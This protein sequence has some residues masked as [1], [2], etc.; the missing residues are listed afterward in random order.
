M[1]DSIL[2]LTL[3]AN[4]IFLCLWLL[5]SSLCQPKAWALDPTV[6]AL[7]NYEI[8]FNSPRERESAS[9]SSALRT[10]APIPIEDY[11]IPLD[12]L[13]ADIAD[14]IPPELMHSLV[15]EK[16]GIKYVRWLINPEDQSFFH[17]VESFLKI[18]GISTERHTYFTAYRT[19]SRSLILEDPATGFQ[20]SAKVSTD[21]AGGPWPLKRG[22]ISGAMQTRFAADHVNIM[23]SQ[24]PFYNFV[25]LD[26]PAMFGMKEIDQSMQVRSLGALPKRKNIYVP[27]FA[28]LNDDLGAR[29]AKLNGSTNPAEYW[30]EHYNKPLGKALG[31]F[32]ART[33]IVYDS[34]H[35]QNFLVEFDETHGENCVPRFW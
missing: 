7:V 4:R 15:F 13:Q 22:T 23:A 20:F 30:N 6:K 11:E 17:E 10:T 27:G 29:L 9:S 1:Q 32:A 24:K 2:H 28:V 16:N 8:N 34:A 31:E 35:S 5:N 14:R 3:A 18:H 12:L 19:A 21:S 25:V 33:G 26:E